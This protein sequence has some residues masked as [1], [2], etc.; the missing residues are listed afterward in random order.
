VLQYRILGPLEVVGEEGPVRLGG[1]KQRATLAILLLSPNRV[2]SVE[3]LADD[4]YSGAAPATAVTQVQRQISELRKL[5]G[6]ASGIETR[7]PGYIIR[8]GPDQLDLNRFE[9]VADEAGEALVLG[10]AKGAAGLYRQALGLW[11]SAPL[12]DLAYEEFAQ[13]PIE[14][15]EEIRL[16]ALEQ[17]IEAELSLG[18]HTDVVAEL[19]TLVAEH[20]L[21]ER[22][23]R[24]LMLALYRSG[25]QAEALEVYGRT[26]EALVGALG[27]EPTAPL[28]QLQREILAQDPSLEFEQHLRRAGIIRESDRVVLV[29]PSGDD[30]LAGLL[31]IA[32]PLAKQSSR[33]LIIARLLAD[34]DEVEH[35]ASALNARR[36]SLPA[37]ARTAAFTSLDRA[38]DAVRLASNYDVEFMLLDAA[39]G[40]EANGLPADVTALLEGSPA[41]VGLLTRLPVGLREGAGIFVPFAGGAH[42]WTALELGA[43]LAFSLSIPLR[44]VG[45]KSDPRHGQRD[46]SRLLADASLAVQRVIGVEAAPLL[47]EPGE[48]TLVAAVEAA[49][50]VVVGISPRWHREGIG[51]SRRALVRDANPPTLLV[52]GGP[53]PGGLAPQA[54]RTR[55]TWSIAP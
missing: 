39:E 41:D 32:E 30:R 5:L 24:Q 52:H 49:T 22:F 1:P 46:A 6:P 33:E 10:D 53:R 28:R 47:A 54:S 23:A 14:R 16:A 2:V 37:G 55:Y 31:A 48:E 29:L 27:I 45:T 50:L 25:R 3:R 35:A 18:F 15:L 26:R 42:D 51:R 40:L 7:A 38:A 17:A 44:V 20:P 9:R 43:W 8:L 4:L 11:R 12:D 36:A 21:R 13:R 34:Q 19:E